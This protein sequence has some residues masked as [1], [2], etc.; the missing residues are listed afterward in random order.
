MEIGVWWMSSGGGP[1]VQVVG[2]QRAVIVSVRRPCPQ[3]RRRLAVAHANGEI[4][5]PRKELKRVEYEVQ[6][7]DFSSV[8]R[9]CE[10]LLTST[11]SLVLR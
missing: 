4:N 3:Q 10:C 9:F 2:L 11:F 5:G 8:F 7:K 6:I 1:G